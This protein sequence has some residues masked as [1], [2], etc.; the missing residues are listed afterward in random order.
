MALAV[1]GAATA[2]CSVAHAA[3]ASATSAPAREVKVAEAAE[4]ASAKRAAVP[5]DGRPIKEIRIEGADLV[6]TDTVRASLRTKVGE[7]YKDSLVQ[8][9]VRGLLQTGKFANV[10]ATRQLDGDQVVVTFH[11]TEKPEAESVEFYGNKKFKAKDLHEDVDLGPGSPL[12]R[13]AVNRGRDNIEQ[14]YKEAGYYYVKVSVDEE[15]L[16]DERRVVYNIV[17]GPRVRVRKIRYEG[18]ESYS[19]RRLKKE[20]KTKRYIWIFRTGDFDQE[21]AER[22]VADLRNFYRNDGFLDVRVSY[23]LETSEDRRDLTLVFVIDEGVR[24]YVETIKSQGNVVFDNDAILLPLKIQ[25]GS[26][27]INE[28]VKSDVEYLEAE[29]GKNGYIYAGVKPEWVYADTPGHI[30]VTLKIDEGNQ[31]RVGRIVVRGNERTK[32][33]VVRRNLRFYPEELYDTTKAKAAERRLRQTRLFSEASVTPVGE[34]EGV[35][36]ALVRVSETET[37]TFMMGAG[38]TSNSGVVGTLSVENRN[39]DLFDTPRSGTEFFRGKAFKGAGQILRFQAE[40][41]TEFTRLRVDFREPYLLDQPVS[42]GQGFYLFTRG[43]DAYHETRVGSQTSFGHRFQTGP[44]R[45]WAG[46]VALRIEGVDIGS[47]DY[48][49]AREIREMEGNHF[50]TSVKGTLVR[51]TTD[52]RFM[53]TRGT[54]FSISYEQAGLVG[55]DYNFGKMIARHAWH[56]TLR[57]DIFDRKSVLTVHG[58]AGQ[59]FGEAPVFER[60]FGGGLGSIRGFEYR[61]V[62]PRAGIN[63]DRVGG[64]FMLVGGAE[65]NFPIYGKI[66]RG[67]GFTDM[68]TVEEDFGITTWRMAVGFGVRVT[69]EWFGPIPMAFDFSIP[70]T[71]D[72]ADDTQIFQFSFGTTF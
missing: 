28:W 25:P 71:Q 15:L 43:R 53:P 22:D 16:K 42:F 36:D 69:V 44:L 12:D 50:V 59:I 7:P 47:I 60:F 72:E 35:R 51:D 31:F 52:S 39:F 30:H 29:Y 64:N 14:R 27:Y 67:V 17:E 26:A 48:D 18:N 63:D 56:R 41:G 2:Q 9:D 19:D 23:R 21:R 68:G 34:E 58:R 62:S 40:P 8:Q 46:E 65:Y 32:D 57:T 33:K 6:S 5:E 54:R 1:A 70:V 10:Y 4:K 61:G 66:L 13:F 20:V 55:G 11:V 24:Y 45:G 3:Q 37:T 38:V 49:D